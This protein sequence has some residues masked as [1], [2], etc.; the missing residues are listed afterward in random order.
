MPS[1]P[2]NSHELKLPSVPLMWQLTW[3]PMWRPTDAVSH[4]ATRAASHVDAEVKIRTIF[5]VD[6]E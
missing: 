2:P 5:S 6:A 4:V 3:P 1:P